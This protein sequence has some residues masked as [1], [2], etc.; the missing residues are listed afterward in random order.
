MMLDIDGVITYD[1]VSLRAPLCKDTESP[2]F[3]SATARSAL[4]SETEAWTF[5]PDCARCLTTAFP[6]EPVA[7][8]T[9]AVL[10]MMRK[11]SGK[12]SK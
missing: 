3:L 11:G 5:H 4:T 9:R 10:D 12:R 6:W 1:A 8:M 7:L 2:N